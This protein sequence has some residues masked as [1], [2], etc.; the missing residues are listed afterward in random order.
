MWYDL[1]YVFQLLKTRLKAKK[2]TKHLRKEDAVQSVTKEDTEC[3]LMSV[4][5]RPARM[6][7]ETLL[8]ISM[9]T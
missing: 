8:Y 9:I 6:E 2:N 5:R 7:T 1:W 3:L 4:G